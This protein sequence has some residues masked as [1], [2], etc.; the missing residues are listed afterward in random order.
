M[1]SAFSISLIS[2]GYFPADLF[3]NGISVDAAGHMTLKF[4]DSCGVSFSVS[5]TASTSGTFTLSGG[6]TNDL[7][8]ATQDD[9]CTLRKQ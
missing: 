5:G 2:Y 8:C 6:N 9:T 1:R 4:V 7:Q 3:R